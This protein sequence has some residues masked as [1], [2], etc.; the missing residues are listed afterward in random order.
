MSRI[1]VARELAQAVRTLVNNS[2]PSA[3]DC[4]RATHALEDYFS[5]VMDTPVRLELVELPKGSS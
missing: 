3:E 2:A 1:A 5:E 4:A